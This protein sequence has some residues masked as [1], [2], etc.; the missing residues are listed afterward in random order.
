MC[1]STPPSGLLGRLIRASIAGA[2]PMS[3]V[4][5]TTGPVET[6]PVA[7]PKPAGPRR[8]RKLW[9]LEEKYHCPVVGTCLSIEEIKKIAR[10]NGFA[11]HAFDEYRLH[12][13]AVSVSCARNPA[14]EAMQRLLDRKFNPAITR[15]ERARAD[16]EVLAL[17]RESL[18][19]GEVAGPMWATLSHKAASPATRHKV[20]ADVH[21]LS[22]QVGAG[23]AADLRRR[24][25]LERERGQLL[26]DVA[27]LREGQRRQA[28][29]LRELELAHTAALE[30]NAHLAPLLQRVRELESGQAMVAIG[31]RLM[32]AE[33]QAGRARELENRV[34]ALEERVAVLRADKARLAR[35]LEEVSGERDALERLCLVEAP[36]ADCVGD[37]SACAEP[38]RGRCVLCVGG[39]APLLPQYRQL[40]ER[41]GVRLLHHDGGREEALSRLPDLL[42]ASDAVICPT[43]CVGHLAY[44]QLKKHCKQTGKP[45]LLPKSSGVAS[46]AA[47]LTRLAEGQAD[48]AEIIPES[49]GK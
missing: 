22:H 27:G 36:V 34:R 3:A 46:F 19:R 41:L 24:E 25:W 39:R 44:Y 48:L 28:E 7:D 4:E 30:Q 13:E 31:Q 26:A 38:L 12:V 21:M 43:D 16:A 1:A 49:P 20:Y 18:E 45:C 11:G 42:A 33:V 9:E 17:W 10:K 47:A 15:F 40:A 23:Q 37:C 6:T 14:S 29:S 35:E 5:T 8:R 2:D 32:L